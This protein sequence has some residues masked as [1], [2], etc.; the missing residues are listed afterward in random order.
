MVGVCFFDVTLHC[1]GSSDCVYGFKGWWSSAEM[2]TSLTC[3]HMGS[4]A[5]YARVLCVLEY[6]CLFVNKGQWRH[7]FVTIYSNHLFYSITSWFIVV[8]ESGRVK[9]TKYSPLWYFNDNIFYTV[10][11]IKHKTYSTFLLWTFN[12]MFHTPIILKF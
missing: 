2:K 4:H 12:E 1:S 10:G 9:M 5:E 3:L 7:N 6:L 11:V 8:K